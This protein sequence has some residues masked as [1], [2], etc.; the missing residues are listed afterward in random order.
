MGF[1]TSPPCSAASMDPIAYRV[2]IMF[3]MT[4]AHFF[5]L[6]AL[7]LTALWLSPE[8]GPCFLVS[9]PLFKPFLFLELFLL[10]ISTSTPPPFLLRILFCEPFSDVRNKEL[11][12]SLEH[13]LGRQLTLVWALKP[14]SPGLKSWL[15][16]LPSMWQWERYISFWAKL[17]Y[18]YGVETGNI[19][20][21]LINL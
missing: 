13:K 8:F 20:I 5:Q 16:Y 6:S 14:K 7:S 1:I 10:S 12:L 19:N 9:V 3:N 18:P 4:L 21:Y 15:C 11:L 17:L 2:K